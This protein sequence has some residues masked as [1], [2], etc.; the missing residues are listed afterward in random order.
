MTGNEFLK[1]LKKLAKKE[2]KFFRLDR[3]FG[4]GS[5]TG[6]YYGDKF[7]TLR[8]PKDELMTGTFNAM[9]KQLGVNKNDLN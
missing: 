3:S 6:V 4:K 8:D 9:L 2:K 7:T 5:H 1:K